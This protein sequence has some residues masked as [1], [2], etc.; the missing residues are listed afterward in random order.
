MNI[1]SE[2][3]KA[4]IARLEM[5]TV[6]NGYRT[7]AGT[8]VRSGWLNE[9]LASSK[10][11]LPLIVVSKAKGLDPEP[12]AGVIKTFCGFNIIGAVQAGVDDYEDAL[13]DLELDILRCVGPVIGAH[14]RWAPPGVCGLSLG[15]A[16]QFPPGAGEPAASVLVPV[17][18]HAVVRTET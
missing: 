7:D 6:A 1:L 2:A 16:E 13:D 11:A 5:I 9:V 4:L 18:L 10:T 14:I 3:R 17:Y 12:G 8:N 15:P